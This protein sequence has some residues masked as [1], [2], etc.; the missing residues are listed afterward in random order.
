MKPK[1]VISETGIARPT[2]I[3]GRQR[4][5]NS[6]TVSVASTAPNS[7]EKTVSWTASRIDSEKSATPSPSLKCM[8][9]GSVSWSWWMRAWISSAIATV[10]PSDCFSTPTPTAGR[11]SKRAM[12]RA[13]SWPSSTRA[14]SRS[15]TGAPSA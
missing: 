11:P 6:Q 4:R 13:S 10:L 7:R 12:V 8:S 15:M 3:V 2:I 1:V 9:S 14:T 5:R